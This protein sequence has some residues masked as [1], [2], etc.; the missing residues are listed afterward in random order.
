MRS[1]KSEE[2]QKLREMKVKSTTQLY[3]IQFNSTLI[4]STYLSPALLN[5]TQHYKTQLNL[6]LKPNLTVP[7]ITAVLVSFVN[8]SRFSW[9]SINCKPYVNIIESG[10]TGVFSIHGQ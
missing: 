4:N 1:N 6:T 7:D 8:Y 5:Y 3:S 2:K 10:N 9:S